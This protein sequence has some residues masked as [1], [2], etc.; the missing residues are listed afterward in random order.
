MKLKWK[1]RQ[2]YLRNS[3]TRI[4]FRYG[5]AC[6]TVSPQAILDVEIEVDGVVVHGFSGDCLPPSWFDKDPSKD[7]RQQVDEMLAACCQACDEFRDTFSTSE[8]FFPG[9]LHVYHHQQERGSSQQ[10][11][12]LLTSFGVSMV[13]RAVMDAICRAKR[14][15]FGDAVRENLFGIDAGLVH[16]CLSSHSPGD[17]LPRESRTSLYA[18]HTVGLG[19]PLTDDEV[20]ADVAVDG[21][22][23]SLQAYV[24]RHG[25]QYFKIKVSNRLQ[26]DIERLSRIAEIV[27]TDRGDKYHVTLDGN[28]QYKTIGD[29]I[30]LIEKIAS[31]EKLATFWKNTLLIEQP[32]A[33]AVALDE[34]LAADLHQLPGQ[35]PVIIDESDGTLDSF[36]RAVQCGYRGVSTKNCK[37]PIKSILNAGVI[38]HLNRDHP[39]K[40]LMSAEDLCCV[41]VV[42]LQ[43]DLCLVAALGIEHVER[44]GH[45]YHPGLG[46]LPVSEQDAVLAAH[47]DLYERCGDV[48]APKLVDG[49]FR[50][51]S[52]QCPGFGFAVTPDVQSMVRAEDWHFDSLYD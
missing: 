17:W 40:Y 8:R 11:P 14:M 43:A 15:P 37:G 33:R 18:R 45:H 10:W 52:L 38:W 1:N 26:H 12:A 6:M 23:R 4:P 20:E 50:V 28:E 19:D 2:L 48:V 42:A 51:G 44:N 30:Q 34:S 46:Y 21:F 13:E 16:Q 9:W 41:G 36:T 49:K 25:Q 3:R 22:P 29:L 47:D 31:S 27:Q 7:F 32:L 39:G 24:S 5:S 35:K